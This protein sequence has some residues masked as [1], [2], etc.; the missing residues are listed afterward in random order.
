MTADTQDNAPLTE[1]LLLLL[2][3]ALWGGSFTL[4]KVALESYP[5]MTIVT[6]RILLGGFILTALAIMRRDVFPKTGRRWSELLIQGTL[7][8]GLP[9]FLITWAEKYVDSSVAGIVNSTPPMFVFLI[10]VFVLHSAKFDMLKFFGI[11]AGMSGVAVIAF[12]QGSGIQSSN[13]MAVM[14][15]LAA[16]CS[17]ACGAIYGRRFGDQSAFVTGGVSLLLATILIG[18]AALYFEAPFALEPT[19]RATVALIALSVFST[20]LASLIFFRLIKTLGSL[21]TTSNAYL[22]ALFSILLGAVFLG[23]NITSSMIV[24]S[25]LIFL[26]V[27]LVTGQFRNIVVNKMLNKGE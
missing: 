11:L 4:I 17:Y 23:E 19:T 16:S 1:Y 13:V 8:G 2:L 9:F 10:T 26:G 24:A 20:A 12:S 3:A 14:A 7:Q 22:R 27:F 18:P 25:F 6:T 21:A 5:P 15:V